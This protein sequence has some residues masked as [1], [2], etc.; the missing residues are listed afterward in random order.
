MK[1]R[2]KHLLLFALIA[3]TMAC[4]KKVEVEPEIQLLKKTG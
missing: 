4:K 1:H 3:G 2:L